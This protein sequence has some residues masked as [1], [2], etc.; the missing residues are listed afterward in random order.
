MVELQCDDLMIILNSLCIQRDTLDKQLLTH[1]GHP[2]SNQWRAEQ[3]NI[4]MVIVRIKTILWLK[5]RLN[6]ET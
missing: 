3:T 4:E 1:K 6:N 2:L 5:K